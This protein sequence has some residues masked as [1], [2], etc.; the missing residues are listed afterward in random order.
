MIS[1]KPM[2][3]LALM[4]LPVLT[5]PSWKDSTATGHRRYPVRFLML[6]SDVYLLLIFNE[7]LLVT[8]FIIPI[9]IQE[10]PLSVTDDC[11]F[12]KIFHP[13]KRGKMPILGP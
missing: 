13:R 1:S 7:R 8:T 12:S 10:I 3:L 11:L 2:G 9:T 4:N 5:L 6:S